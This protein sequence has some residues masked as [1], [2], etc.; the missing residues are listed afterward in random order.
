MDVFERRW[1][2][3]KS[4][5]AGPLYRNEVVER[6]QALATD[7]DDESG[8]SEASVSADVKALRALEVGLRQLG[9]NDKHTKQAYELDMKLLD[10]FTCPAEAEAL[11]AA[12]EVF[13]ELRLPE[14]AI[15]KTLLDRVPPEVR[16]GLP[17]TY[18][19]RLLRTGIADYDP[20]VL[21]RLKQGIRKGRMMR[22][23]YQ[24]LGRDAKRYLVDR[25]YLTW[26]DGSLY[27]RA[28]CPEAPG[29]PQWQRNREFRVDRFCTEGDH[30]AVEVLQATAAEADVP[31][32]EFELWL[33]PGLARGFS[34]VPGRLRVIE[35]RSDGSRVLAVRE[36]IPLRA[37]RRVLSYGSQARVLAPDYLVTEVRAAIA[38]MAH[39]LAPDHEP[40]PV[41]L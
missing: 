19:D 21:A 16:D 2:L 13:E 1:N 30:P 39:D 35:E 28:Y 40:F 18:G 12:A 25:A 38:R 17:K 15:L 37:V 29:E 36:C 6:L 3:I 9:P 4:L 5:L 24:P 14:A 23:T 22:I 33:A 11:A 7:G 32:F 41:S 8:L 31:T 20:E 26:V 34:N 27:L 10:L